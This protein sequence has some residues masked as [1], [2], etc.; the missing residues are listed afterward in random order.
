LPNG[1]ARFDFRGVGHYSKRFF[2]ELLEIG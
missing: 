2:G 1:L